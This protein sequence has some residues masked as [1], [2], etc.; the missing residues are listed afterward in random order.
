MCPA[1]YAANPPAGSR[2]ASVKQSPPINKLLRESGSRDRS[3]LVA[4]IQPAAVAA[5]AASEISGFV[6][7]VSPRQNPERAASQGLR[8]LTNRVRDQIAAMDRNTPCVAS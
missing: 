1:K 8:E 5:R 7:K 2:D 6:R 4:R 3:I